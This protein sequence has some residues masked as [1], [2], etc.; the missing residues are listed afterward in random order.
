[1]VI[2][3]RK[4]LVVLLFISFLFAFP[5]SAGAETSV[6]LTINGMNFKSDSRMIDNHI[7]IP[8]ESFAQFIG[9][10]YDKNA[11]NKMIILKQDKQTIQMAI[12]S[13]TL[14]FNDMPISLENAPI[15][16]DGKT[17]LPV[18]AV[19]KA[20]KYNVSWDPG[21]N[22]IRLET[23]KEF[24]EYKAISNSFSDLIDE[25]DNLLMQ[26]QFPKEKWAF[27]DKQVSVMKYRLKNWNQL[28]EYSKIKSLYYEALIDGTEACLLNYVP[29]QQLASQK[30][31]EYN[32]DKQDI[33]TE[34]SL[35]QKAGY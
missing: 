17:M 27:L 6:K 33:Q 28:N 8:V 9:V 15:I 4:V 16:I 13:N 35:L 7:Y 14:Y 12:N 23:K 18:S 10:T 24:L 32:K 5:F 2:A 31:T 30:A 1:M 34:A 20:L 3:L 26:K 25:M 11:Q 29:D 19:A 22:M 21:L